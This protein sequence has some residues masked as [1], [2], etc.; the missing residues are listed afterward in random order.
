MISSYN[1]L[2]LLAVTLASTDN[3]YTSGPID[4]G[5]RAIF[6]LDQ[7]F[8]DGISLLGL[9]HFVRISGSFATA[10]SCIRRKIIASIVSDQVP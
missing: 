2:D 7:A 1:S 10:A 5:A 6:M 9:H 3:P 4:V 8:A